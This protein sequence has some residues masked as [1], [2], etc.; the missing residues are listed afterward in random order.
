MTW[1][2][3]FEEMFP[4][5]VMCNIFKGDQDSWE[6]DVTD[7]LKS[8]IEE[9]VMEAGVKAFAKG[10]EAGKNHPKPETKCKH[11]QDI[12]AC[13]ICGENV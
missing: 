8:F 7:E 6:L 2:D 5:G 3:R 11:G 9:V 4:S 13:F 12:G 10:Y 1:L